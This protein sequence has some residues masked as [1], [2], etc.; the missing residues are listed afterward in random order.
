MEKA[1]DNP[2]LGPPPA[3][4]FWMIPSIENGCVWWEPIINPVTNKLA[5]PKVF[6]NADKTHLFHLQNNRQTVNK[7][8]THITL[9]APCPN[10]RK[11]KCRYIA[12]IV[13]SKAQGRL[14]SFKTKRCTNT[15]KLLTTD[16]THSTFRAL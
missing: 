6:V 13:Y 11:H 8:G 1:F 7:T 10:K 4:D 2:V 3:R 16:A 9:H 14:V 12:N 5:R 15:V